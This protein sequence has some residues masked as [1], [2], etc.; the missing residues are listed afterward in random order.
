MD[1]VKGLNFKDQLLGARG[2]GAFA[3]TSLSD[4]IL[5]GCEVTVSGGVATIGAGHFVVGGR[6]VRIS[7]P[8][9]VGAV[10]AA[11]SRIV[12]TVDLTRVSTKEEFDQVQLTIET[13]STLAAL[14]T[15]DSNDVNLSATTHSAWL[16][17]YEATGAATMSYYQESYHY[18]C[19][20]SKQL[21]WKNPNPLAGFSAQGLRLPAMHGFNSFEVLFAGNE[22]LTAPLVTAVLNLPG[23][24]YLREVTTSGSALLGEKY[25]YFPCSH[26]GTLSDWTACLWERTVYIYPELDII[27][28]STGWWSYPRISNSSSYRGSGANYLRPLKIFGLNAHQDMTP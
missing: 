23:N 3:S 6:L 10:G 8:V 14:M 25:F 24:E 22:K 9:Q 19:A 18:A 15:D 11:F 5:N 2:F 7:S 16:W 28:F 17:V 4:G 20:N 12:A 13:A 26:I 1:N 27:E 21:I